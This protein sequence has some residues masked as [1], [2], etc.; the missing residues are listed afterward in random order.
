MKKRKGFLFC[1]LMIVVLV[2]LAGC[3]PSPTERSGTEG[4]GVKGSLTLKGEPIVNATILVDDNI[5]K[6]DDDGY[7][8]LDLNPGEYLLQVVT[9]FK[10]EPTTTKNINVVEDKQ[11]EININYS[12]EE[13]G[14]ESIM[15]RR[16]I[17]YQERMQLITRHL[18]L[19]ELSQQYRDH[20]YGLRLPEGVIYYNFTEDV[21]PIEQARIDARNFFDIVEDLLKGLVTFEEGGDDI[22]IT[23]LPEDEISHCKYDYVNLEGYVEKATIKMSELLSLEEYNRSTDLLEIGNRWGEY[24]LRHELAHALGIQHLYITDDV[25]PGIITIPNTHLE[26]S[27]YKLS[28]SAFNDIEIK[29]LKVMYS[30][31]PNR[32]L[33]WA[34]LD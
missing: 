20:N 31:K 3:E 22:T 30:V 9:L 28:S 17:T 8:S 19:F 24:V 5:V 27:E 16:E 26:D 32:Q 4:S 18:S 23:T 2:F 11:L 29:I 25:E 34:F 33:D 13:L 15:S 1:C 14:L 10:E 6:V 21:V 7:F 12:F